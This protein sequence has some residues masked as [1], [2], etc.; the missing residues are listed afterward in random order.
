[1]TKFDLWVEFN[2]ITPNG[3]TIALM[4]HATMSKED[5]IAK[6]KKT[7]GRIIVGDSEGNRCQAQ[8]KV[9]GK[10]DVIELRLL[11]HTFKGV[12]I[13]GNSQTDRVDDSGPA[14]DAG[15]GVSGALGGFGK[16]RRSA[17]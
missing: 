6:V 5:F 10:H 8:V 1:M 7:R 11:L 13:R 4:R 12:D 2:D 14:P 3:D 15:A 16:R 17:R 9:V